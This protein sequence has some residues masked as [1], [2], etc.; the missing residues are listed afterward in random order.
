VPSGIG[1]LVLRS[2]GFLQ[3]ALDAFGRKIELHE[4]DAAVECFAVM[5]NQTVAKSEAADALEEGRAFQAFRQKRGVTEPEA[6]ISNRA[7]ADR[8]EKLPI[9]ALSG[10]VIEALPVWAPKKPSS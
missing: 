1:E 6:G 10:I 4:G 8:I 9:I 5:G 7:V 2:R 3:D